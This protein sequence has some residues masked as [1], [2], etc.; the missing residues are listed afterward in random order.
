M[1]HTITAH[2]DS[3]VTFEA[4]CLD[5]GQESGG[6]PTAADTDTW[7]L[8]HAGATGHMGFRRLMTSFALVTRHTR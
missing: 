7:A 1:D 8:R 3:D 2:P 4:Q 5:C 6:L